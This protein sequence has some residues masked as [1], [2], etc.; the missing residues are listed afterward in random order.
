MLRLAV[1]LF[2]ITLPVLEL[3]VLIKTGQKFGL[4]STVLLLVGAALAGGAIISRQSFTVVNK[5]LEALSEGR[6]PVAGVIDGLF[7]M[8]AGF[9]LVI[10]GLISDGLAFLLLI[11]PLRRAFAR[12]SMRQALELR[13][14]DDHERVA[15]KAEQRRGSSTADRPV[16]D[17]EFERLSETPPQSGPA[18]ERQHR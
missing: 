11:P 15:P 3:A 12:W 13:D 16:I 8:L 18:T 9:L 4:L 5:T 10:P 2:L 14:A 6:P 1:G 7:L 17:G